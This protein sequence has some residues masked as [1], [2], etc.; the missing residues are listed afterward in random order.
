MNSWS[1][2]FLGLILVVITVYLWGM[3]LWGL[4]TSALM[5]LKGGISWL[6]ILIGIGLIIIGINDLK[7]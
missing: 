7:E 3:N 1:K 5:F 4:G 2:L 6:I